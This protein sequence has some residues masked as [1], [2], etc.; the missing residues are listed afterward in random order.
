MYI[1]PNILKIFY[2]KMGSDLNRFYKKISSDNNNLLLWVINDLQQI[3]NYINDNSLKD[4]T[5]NEEINLD[6]EESPRE[7]IPSLSIPNDI[8]KDVS[9][10]N[11]K[12]EIKL[13]KKKQRTEI[14]GNIR[15]DESFIML[16]KNKAKKINNINL[17]NEILKLKENYFHYNETHNNEII[18]RIE[19]I[20]KKII[21]IYNDNKKNTELVINHFSLL[22]NKI[23]EM[24]K[25][26][27]EFENSSINIQAKSFQDGIYL[28]NVLKG[29]REGEGIML[30]NNGESFIGHWKNDAQEE[31]GIFYYKNGDK[32]DGEW[33]N[34]KREGK[35]IF[36]YHNGDRYEGDWK[37]DKK[38]GKGIIYLHNGD[39]AMGDFS[40]G[41]KR[42]KFVILTK[43][44]ETNSMDFK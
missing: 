34:G 14:Q 16:N 32:Y 37:N 20:I 43:N 39:R 12:Y 15:K 17:S 1:N 25:N 9:Q 24:S 28:G 26:M 21:F 18:K 2:I 33:I 5:N 3:T 41:C 23:D 22:K 42:G 8:Q 13:G 44:G 10:R 31:K 36:Y 6:E 35:G 11:K 30:F 29:E 40:N 7:Q 19:N 38:D 4:K 27:N